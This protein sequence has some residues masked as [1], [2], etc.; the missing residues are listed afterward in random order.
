[1]FSFTFLIGPPWDILPVFLP[2][3]GERLFPEKGGQMLHLYHL[4]GIFLNAEGGLPYSAVN[5]RAKYFGSEK[6]TV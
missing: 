5:T 2:G 1:M 4:S 3:K 6:P